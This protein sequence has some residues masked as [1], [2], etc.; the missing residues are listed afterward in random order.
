MTEK[1]KEITA[2]K[3]QVRTITQEMSRTNYANASILKKMTID[4]GANEYKNAGTQTGKAL[5]TLTYVRNLHTED[6]DV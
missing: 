3:K 5:V 4:T 2:F 6:D 1:K